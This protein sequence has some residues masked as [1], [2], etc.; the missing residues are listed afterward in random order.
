MNWM[1][2][3]PFLSVAESVFK[4]VNGLHDSRCRLKDN[5]YWQAML[6]NTPVRVPKLCEKETWIRGG[7]FFNFSTP[8]PTSEEMSLWCDPKNPTPVLIPGVTEPVT[9]EAEKIGFGSIPAFVETAYEIVGDLEGTLKSR[10]GGKDARELLRLRRRVQEEYILESLNTNQLLQQTD[11]FS[12]VVRLLLLNSEKHGAK[13][14][15]YQESSLKQLLES[16][17]SD[18]I[19]IFLRR[20]RQGIAV[21]AL[22]CY[23]D[24]TNKEL[25][26]ATQGIDH[27]KVEPKHNLYTTAYLDLFELA[28]REGYKRVWLGRGKEKDKLRIGANYARNLY[29][30][31]WAP[32]AQEEILKLQRYFEE[33]S[34]SS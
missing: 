5:L 4:N 7:Y 15:L 1:H 32:N 26:Y 16:S 10:L 9:P 12:E 33:P 20:N 24:R 14:A 21:Q 13:T 11:L 30:W 17:I 22:F 25:F 27:E 23:D 19:R 31:I 8:V 29:Y 3:K 34:K 6:K 2:E 18:S 28:E